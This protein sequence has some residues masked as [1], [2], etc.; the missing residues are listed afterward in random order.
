[1][2][3]IFMYLKK[4]ILK[5]LIIQFRAIFINA[6]PGIVWHEFHSNMCC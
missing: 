3:H 6:E 4:N 2:L 1:M 5:K